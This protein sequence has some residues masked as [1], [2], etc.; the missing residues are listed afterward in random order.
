MELTGKCKDDF[1]KWYKSKNHHQRINLGMFNQLPIEF[2][3]GLLIDFFDSVGIYISTMASHSHNFKPQYHGIDICV[4][5]NGFCYDMD[6]AD[7]DRN[8][9]RQKAIK[10]ADDIY[11]NL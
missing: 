3:Y 10:K 5:G 7:K 2:K 6:D 4:E 8:I 1:E 9:A 11:N